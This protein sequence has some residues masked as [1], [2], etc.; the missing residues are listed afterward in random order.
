MIRLTDLVCS[1]LSSHDTYKP[2]GNGSS[3]VRIVD[4]FVMLEITHS[5]DQWV[6]LVAYLLDSQR[7]LVNAN[8]LS[9]STHDHDHESVDRVKIL[10][11]F[12]YCT[13]VA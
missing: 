11:I 1:Y 9:P 4:P 13:A 3:L 8:A 10:E 2:G 7:H 5:K 6:V 12:L